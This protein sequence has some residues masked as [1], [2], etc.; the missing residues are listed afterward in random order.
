MLTNRNMLYIK[1]GIEGIEKVLTP[2][3]VR[4]KNNMA[5]IIHC[6]QMNKGG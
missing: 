6:D 2:G 5:V 1:G 4:R 3:R